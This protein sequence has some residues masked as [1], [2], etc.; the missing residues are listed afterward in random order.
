M[1]LSSLDGIELALVYRIFHCTTEFLTEHE[2]ILKSSGF[3]FR[4][5]GQLGKRTRFQKD[6]KAQ[7]T[8]VIED[9]AFLRNESGLFISP[10]VQHV[11]EVKLGDDIATMERPVLDVEQNI[12]PLTTKELC[13]LLLE[14]LAIADRRASATQHEERMPILNKV[15]E[16]EAPY[17]IITCALYQKALVEK[18]DT[19]VQQR[20]ALQLEAIMAELEKSGP[21]SRLDCFWVLNHPPMWEIRREMG[22]Q[23]L[24]IGAARTAS[25]IFIDHQMWDELAVCCGLAKDLDLA[26]NTLQVQNP[27]PLVLCLLGELRQDVSLLAQSWHLSGHRFARAQR[28]IGKHWLHKE[29][30]ELAISAFQLALSLNTLYPDIWFS[31]GCSHMRLNQF[32]E[33][34]VAFQ[35]VV[36]QKQDDAESFSNLAIC[37]MTVGKMIE[38]HKAV[39]QA[40]RFDRHNQKVWENFVVISLNCELYGDVVYGLEEL[41]RAHPKWCNGPLL[42]EVSQAVVPKEAERFLRVMTGISQNADCPFEFFVI[43]GD[44]LENVGDALNAFNMRQEAV[45]KIERDG[46]V[47]GVN[48]FGKL[49]FAVEKL[50]ESARKV[51]G[52]AKGIGQRIKVLLKKYGDE[53]GNDPGYAKLQNLL[54]F[55]GIK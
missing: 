27:T 20:A 37:L 54:E 10:T 13:I 53:F 44:V 40:I 12:S 39:S 23:F 19:Y 33:A 29:E 15:L 8:L 32:D 38:A 6:S 46:K 17:S 55:L 5:S 25:K 30:W 50:V 35:E 52:K 24:M 42:L 22:M 36:S 9:S 21:A 49:V 14:T 43:F 41:T 4:I 16:C 18:H 7:M 26:I 1:C 34:I 31:L 48:G 45:K 51:E 28:A 2:N 3:A 11:R 47:N